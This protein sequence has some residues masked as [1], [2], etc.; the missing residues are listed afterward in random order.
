M[1]MSRWRKRKQD[2][3][4]QSRFLPH[5]SQIGFAGFSV[6]K[7]LAFGYAEGFTPTG[8][9]VSKRHPHSLQMEWFF[10]H[11]H[12]IKKNNATNWLS[13]QMTL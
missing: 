10:D 2:L 6:N 7:V 9:S 4:C 12:L 3:D 1:M 5:T 13:N 11:I 8:N